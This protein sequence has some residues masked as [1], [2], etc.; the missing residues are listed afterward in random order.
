M[1]KQEITFSFF[2]L[3][4]CLWAISHLIS[5]KVHLEQVQDT[6]AHGV[7]TTS[8]I[9]PSVCCQVSTELCWIP[10]SNQFGITLAQTS[11]LYIYA[12]SSGGALKFYSPGTDI[13]LALTLLCCFTQPIVS[14]PVQAWWF[15]LFQCLS[16]CCERRETT[17]ITKSC[18]HHWMLLSSSELQKCFN[19]WLPPLL[20]SWV[21]T[22]Q[23]SCYPTFH[24][25]RQQN[26]QWLL[27][28]STFASEK[29]QHLFS[30]SQ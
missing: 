20:C 12:A 19:S 6:Q 9:A 22:S 4:C 2:L 24:S 15:F 29:L 27:E 16:T 30:G 11:G 21:E 7:Q 8:H 14:P 28:C 10:R 18:R 1:A 17:E 5:I 23:S 25:G 13:F 26:I 3:L